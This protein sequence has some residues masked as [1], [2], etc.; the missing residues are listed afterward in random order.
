MHNPGSTGASQ[1]GVLERLISEGELGLGN[2]AA[3]TGGRASL[4]I[5]CSQEAGHFYD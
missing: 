5:G 1:E 4:L 2:S 3:G